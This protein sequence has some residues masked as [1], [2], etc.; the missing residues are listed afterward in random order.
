M[1]VALAFES[2]DG[3]RVI[4]ATV[5]VLE[6]DG[7]R[8]DDVGFETYYEIARTLEQIRRGGYKNIALQFPDSLLPD[9]PRVQQELKNGLESCGYE[10]IFILGDTSYG[11]CC[12]DEVAAQHLF[13]DCIVHYGRTCLSATSSIP[14]VY[15]FGN[16]P[17]DA[18]Q[19]VEL[20]AAQI[21]SSIDAQKTI[22]LLYEPSYHHATTAVFAQLQ[23]RFCDTRTFLLADMTTFYNP[24]EQ[25]TAIAAQDTTTE[26]SS[27]VFIGGQEVKL[28]DGQQIT[29]ETFAFLYIGAESAHLTSIL[30]RYSTVECYSYNPSTQ[31]LRREGAAVNR[32]LMRRYFLVQQAKEAQIYGIL[33]GTLGVSKYLDV[34]H[35]LQKLIKK[36]GRKSY[37]FVVGKVN[38]PKLANYAEIDAFVLVACQQNTLMDSKEFYK[39]IVTPYEL[40]MALSTSEEWTG[41]YKT[42]FR[43][44]L[45]AITKAMGDLDDADGNDG[46]GSDDDDKPFFSLL[47]GTYKNTVRSTATSTLTASSE[48]TSST[49]LQVKNDRSELV[50]Y[51]SEA[52]EFL[53]AR[54][55]RGLEPRIGETPAHAAVQ[56]ATGIARGYT[57]E[58]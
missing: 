16:A 34:V 14:V 50:A 48:E 55:Y 29:P 10:R 42:D 24:S 47:T 38:V 37:L 27:S 33:M 5:E 26:G 41:E 22:V 52:G 43:E 46:E 2:D 30:L 45:P 40:Q 31:S 4:Q 1:T 6:Q 20:F 12:V 54:E 53:A 21:A 18:G 56:G 51:K 7:V 58:T 25:T 17:I 23:E 57:H 11:S 8:T 35:G 15:V 9:A 13:A 32:A 44:V 36:S 49:A 19:C 28:A 39:P 3:S